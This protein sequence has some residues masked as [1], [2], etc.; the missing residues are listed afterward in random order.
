MNQPQTI[1]RVEIPLNPRTCRTWSEKV[2]LN[3]NV[4][5]AVSEAMQIILSRM[6]SEGYR[7][8]KKNAREPIFN[9]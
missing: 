7:Y 1:V 5:S 9:S 6:K 2:P 3:G 8:P 4:L